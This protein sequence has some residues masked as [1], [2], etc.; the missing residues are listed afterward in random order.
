MVLAMLP[1][2]HVHFDK[3]LGKLEFPH[4]GSIVWFLHCA[5]ESRRHAL[6]VEQ[7]AEARRST[8]RRT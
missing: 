7:L 6:P 5:R 4:N 8:R 1:E 3:Q 2:G